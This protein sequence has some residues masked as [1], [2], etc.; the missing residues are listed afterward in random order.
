VRRRKKEYEKGFGFLKS[1]FY[2]Q[3]NFLMAD[4]PSLQPVFPGDVLLNRFFL[5]PE[6]KAQKEQ[7]R[8]IMR[9]VYATQ[10]SND[11]NLNYF[12]ARNAR[13]ITNLLWAKGSQDIREFLGYMNVSD[14][15]KAWVNI[16]TTQTRIATQFV[17]T[18]VESMAKTKVYPCV[19]AVDDGSLN[20]K[21]QRLYEALFRMHQVQTINDLQQKA[22]VQLEPANA[23]VPDDE[24]AAKVYFEL[25]DQLPKEIRFEK[26]LE[27]LMIDIHFET[28][29]NRKTLYDLTVL[30]CGAT[31]IDRLGVNQYTVRKCIPTNL[32]YNFFMNDNG[33]CEVT[34]IGE[35]YNVKVKDFRTRFGKSDTN[36]NGLDEQAIYELAKLS[37]NR[38]IGTFNYVWNQNWA[39]MSSFNQ[40][41]PYDDC[42]ILVFDAEID[43]PEE[44]Y[45]VEKTDS[46]GKYTIEKKKGVPYQTKKK[47]GTILN[48]PKPD[49]VNIIS[50]KKNTWM[51]G[52]WAP[53]GDTMLYWGPPDIIIS[54][55]T[56]VYKPLSS[57]TLIIPNNDGEYVPSLFERIMEPLRRYQLTIFKIKQ[58]IAL[59]EPDGFRIDVENV[60]NIDLGSGNTIAWEEVVRIKNQTGVEL[61]SSKG[62][63]PLAHEAPPISAGTQS[64]NINKVIELNNVAIA[65]LA[66]I[67]QLIGVPQ[68]RDGSDVGDRTAAALAEGQN[69]NSFNVTDFVAVANNQL[70]TETFYKVCLLHW[71]DI[72][73]GDAESSADM[74]N[75]RFDVRVEVKPTDYQKQQLEQDI[76]RYSQMPD[77]Q[78]NPSISPKDAM[79][80]REIGADNYKLAQWY[81]TSVF[82]SNRKKAIQQSQM[83]QQQN[84]AE[85]QQVAMQG[86]QQEAQLAQQ[87]LDAEKA[88]L[89]FKSG[90]EKELAL[91]NGVFAVAAKSGV[92][93]AEF[94][95]AIQ[96]LVP[97]IEMPLLAENHMMGQQIAAAAQPQAA[98]V[99]AQAPGQQPPGQP[100]QPTGPDSQ[101]Q[102]SQDESNAQA[103]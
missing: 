68:Y 14:A 21:E 18:L 7:G 80:L 66:E 54:Q 100:M 25:Q 56:D 53:Y 41:R 35:F 63:D 44:Q 24:L 42:S 82:E 11:S 77:A 93:P 71:N 74:I 10:T 50:K 2:G 83:L 65:I 79:M 30:N 29:L 81:L 26:V 52:V 47:D 55:Y 37:T 38:A 90:K 5:T 102:N 6:Q 61:W 86:Q 19:K 40:T 57:Y 101:P 89:D 31:K 23:Y 95:P 15:N 13:W 20:E 12:K 59:I 85:Q 92:I 62:V 76:Q 64:N 1:L 70:W 46:F 60:R 88:M 96:A 103:A 99:Q 27:K 98:P 3:T 73:K 78:G 32:V 4:Q 48:Q 91:L 51:R 17:S 87:K 49:N 58:L 69:T 8:L 22:G 84:A 36:P 45:F 97:N 75:T 39:Y 94:L 43:F 28:I 16:D 67:R 34:L 33:E 9:A 72:V